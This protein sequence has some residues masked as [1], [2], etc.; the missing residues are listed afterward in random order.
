[1]LF[2]LAIIWALGFRAGAPAAVLGSLLIDG[3]ERLGPI[4]GLTLLAYVLV[5]VIMTRLLQIPFPSGA[6]LAWMGVQ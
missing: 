4:L 3:R 5:A 1:M 2:F 6:A